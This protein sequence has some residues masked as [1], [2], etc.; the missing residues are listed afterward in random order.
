MMIAPPRFDLPRGTELTLTGNKVSVVGRNASGYDLVDLE[1]GQQ[2]IVPF[3]AFV[4]FLKLP[5]AS[6]NG[7]SRSATSRATP[8][9]TS[10][11]RRSS[12]S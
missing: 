8:T 1:T 10:L 11:R 12:C 9:R 7:L 6:E 4:D 2:R 5:G 3:A